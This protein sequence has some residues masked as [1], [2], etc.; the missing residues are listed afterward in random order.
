MTTSLQERARA[1]LIRPIPEGMP[2]VSDS[3]AE[4]FIRE[5]AANGTLQL[6]AELAE[7][8]YL[9]STVAFEGKARWSNQE[10]EYMTESGQILQAI[11]NEAKAYW[12]L[13]E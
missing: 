1:F 11:L 9:C 2:Y 8:L 4:R 7:M 6:D 12:P 13:D 3:L 5:Y 10:K